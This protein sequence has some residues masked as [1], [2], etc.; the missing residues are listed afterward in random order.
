M[1]GDEENHALFYFLIK[2]ILINGQLL[3]APLAAI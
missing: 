3:H 2:Y 1:S